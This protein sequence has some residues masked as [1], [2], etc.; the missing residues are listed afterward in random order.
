MATAF[1]SKLNRQFV[2]SAAARRYG[3]PHHLG[4]GRF[5]VVAASK[6]DSGQLRKASSDTNISL[7]G[8]NIDLL[9]QQKRSYGRG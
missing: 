5:G 1:I 3:S 4:K 9:H 8:T 6:F 2:V 7:L